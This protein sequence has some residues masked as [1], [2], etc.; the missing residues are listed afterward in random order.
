MRNLQ[1]DV[2]EGHLKLVTGNRYFEVY[3]LYLYITR[4]LYF[5]LKSFTCLACLHELYCLLKSANRLR[6]VQASFAL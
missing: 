6:S 4:R 1:L 5:L 2:R 3:A